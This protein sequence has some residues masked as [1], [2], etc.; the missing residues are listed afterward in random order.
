MNCK[1]LLIQ[2][3]NNN[4][5]KAIDTEFDLTIF[6]RFYILFVQQYLVSSHMS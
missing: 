1:V 3:F 4:N 5:N 2:V 6:S